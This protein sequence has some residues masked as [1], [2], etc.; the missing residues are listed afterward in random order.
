MIKFFRNS[1]FINYLLLVV[2]ALLLWLPSFIVLPAFCHPSGVTPLY[3]FIVTSLGSK[4]L[5][6]QIIAFLLYIVEAFFFN[7]IMVV[8]KIEPKVS[9]IGTLTFILLM[10]L[11]TMQT[12]FQPALLATAFVLPV[13]FVLYRI[14]TQQNVEMD[15]L[16]AGICIA[17]ATMSYLYSALLLIWVM[18]ALA[19]QKSSRF[20]LHIIPIIGFLLPYFFYFAFHF[21]KGDL[22]DVAMAYSV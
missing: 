20:R 6:L 8:G 18:I 17:F 9:T 14:P 16:N 12:A 1:Y 10:G 5:L 7:E 4:P 19:I 15:L 3:D 11:T 21:L 13:L 2:M 22:V